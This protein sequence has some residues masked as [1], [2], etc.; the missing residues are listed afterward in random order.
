MN[1]IE[2]TLPTVSELLKYLSSSNMKS[3]CVD[4]VMITG[5]KNKIHYWTGSDGDKYEDYIEYYW[6]KDSADFG[7]VQCVSR[8]TAHFISKKAIKNASYSSND[9][10]ICPVLKMSPEMF[11]KFSKKKRV[12]YGEY[13]QYKVIDDKL[14]DKLNNLFRKNS[15]FKTGKSFSLIFNGNLKSYDE[16]ELEGYKYIYFSPSSDWIRVDPVEWIVNEKTCS[17]I[18]TMG[19]LSGVQFDNK[20]GYYGK[21]EDTNMYKFLNETMLPDLL[22]NR[23]SEKRE[24]LIVNDE[25]K[26]YLSS[27][28]IKVSDLVR[29]LNND[30]QIA[31]DYGDNNVTT[32]S[33]V[34]PII[35]DR[36]IYEY[37]VRNKK[38]DKLGNIYC[39]LG[40]YPQSIPDAAIQK[41]MRDSKL[42]LFSNDTYTIYFPSKE[43]Y[44][45]NK[46]WPKTS[47]KFIVIPGK[48]KFSKDI[49]V[50]IEP[51]KWYIDEERKVLVCQNG[52]MTNIPSFYK[53]F[54]EEKLIPEILRI[55][56]S[57]IANFKYDDSVEKTIELSPIKSID[58]MKKDISSIDAKDLTDMFLSKLDEVKNPEDRRELL[59]EFYKLM[60]ELERSNKVRK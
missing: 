56:T 21:F 5:A 54:S 33:V 59:L 11:S 6:T 17:L 13:P 57:K 15:L 49:Y 51:V 29:H 30:S 47:E 7:E 31:F 37:A 9:C 41:E 35:T 23:V 53:S 55:E 10:T 2:M 26:E 28:D 1:K 52:L 20:N 36:K 25:F 8:D 46:Y 60:N 4:L 12:T 42:K 50:K 3:G 38:I 48:S 18:S 43:D 22:Q 45:A 40:E 16:Y 32:G 24:S 34:V 44:F 39:E 19:L 58:N 14:N 27:L